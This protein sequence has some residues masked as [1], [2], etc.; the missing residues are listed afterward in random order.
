MVGIIY[1]IKPKKSS[2]KSDVYIGSTTLD[3]TNRLDHH[4]TAYRSWRNGK[5]RKVMVYDLFRKYGPDNC[6]ISIVAKNKNVK[7]GRSLKLL[8]N[9]FIKLGKCMNK[10]RSVKQFKK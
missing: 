7:N 3:I 2:K 9:K 8:E 6:D 1:K 4:K 10:R 5:A